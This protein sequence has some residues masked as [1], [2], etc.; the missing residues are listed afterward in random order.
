MT[1]L[2]IRKILDRE[3]PPADALSPSEVAQGR[4]EE[5]KKRE[6]RTATAPSLKG[7]SSYYISGA[8]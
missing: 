1:N 6:G 8:R 7:G 5:G 2:G 3:I 4:V